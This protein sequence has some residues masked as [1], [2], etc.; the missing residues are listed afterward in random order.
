MALPSIANCMLLTAE[1]NKEKAN[2][3]LEE[4][5]EIKR[6]K[7]KEEKEFAKYLKL[8]LIPE[9]EKLWKME[10]FEE[11]IEARKQLILDKF[12]HLLSQKN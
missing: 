5:L 2:K 1:E 9:D 8:H 7:L 10:N 3:T 11:F 12:N 6:V 4:W